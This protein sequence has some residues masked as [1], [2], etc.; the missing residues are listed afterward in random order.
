MVKEYKYFTPSIEDIRVGY[1]CELLEVSGKLLTGS[2]PDTKWVT[3]KVENS[4]DFNSIWDLYNEGKQTNI[5]VPYLTKEQIEAEGWK[6]GQLE[7]YEK[8]IT[9]DSYYS[10]RLNEN[11]NIVI[12]KSFIEGWSWVWTPFYSGECKD[13]NTFRYICKLLKI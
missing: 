5:R 7:G 9:K 11:N 13:I 1:E 2:I 6:E 12:N 10:L 8:E 3:Y 4:Y